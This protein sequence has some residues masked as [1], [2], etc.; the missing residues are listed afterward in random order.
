MVNKSENIKSL[1]RR[2]PKAKVN[3]ENFS[4]NDNDKFTENLNLK[5]EGSLFSNDI[6]SE[7]K[8]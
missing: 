8:K 7:S 2:K 6:K 1:I 4:E 5:S 3:L